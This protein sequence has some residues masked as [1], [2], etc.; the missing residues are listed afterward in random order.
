MAPVD[1]QQTT[2]ERENRLFHHATEQT[3]KQSRNKGP[4]VIQ[5]LCF[6]LNKF[7]THPWTHV[8]WNQHTFSGHVIVIV[9]VTVI[10][11]DPGTFQESLTE[12]G[13]DVSCLDHDHNPGSACD[14]WR[15]T[16]HEQLENNLCAKINKVFEL[17][18][19]L[20]LDKHDKLLARMLLSKA[21]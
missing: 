9:M 17:S 1:L 21:A 6:S 7:Q 13:V 3:N 12:T 15:N 2:N 19:S 4:S 10:E 11:T 5:R 8:Q 20:Q 18:P 14:W 16:V